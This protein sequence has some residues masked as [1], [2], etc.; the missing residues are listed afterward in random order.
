M[1]YV[2]GPNRPWSQSC[3][4]VV[5]YTNKGLVFTPP[6][7]WLPANNLTQRAGREEAHFKLQAAKGHFL[8]MDS[9]GGVGGGGGAGGG[10]GDTSCCRIFS[11]A[12]S[13]VL[14]RHVGKV[15]ATCET[16]ETLISQQW[17]HTRCLFNETTARTV[18][19]NCARPRQE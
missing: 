12:G 11:V 18:L 1:A 16:C 4:R 17:S 10:G 14:L 8:Q 3:H 15:P 13:H 9:G 5:L 2:M 19:Y 6:A 7:R